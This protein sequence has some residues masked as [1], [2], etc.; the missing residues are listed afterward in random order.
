MRHRSRLPM[1][2]VF[3]L[4]VRAPVQILG[5]E[6]VD[7]APGEI[8][9][10]DQHF[11]APGKDIA[12]WTFVPKGNIKEFST[13]EHPG[14]ATIYEAGAGQDIKGLLRQPIPIGSYRLP[15]EFQTSLVQSFNL[16]AGVGA[17]TQVNAAIG[18]NV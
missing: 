9:A 6:D 2:V 14:L 3:L 12:P 13:T 18:L 10:L 17:K 5:G 11:N 16:T 1:M 7:T 15:W 4:V 8:S